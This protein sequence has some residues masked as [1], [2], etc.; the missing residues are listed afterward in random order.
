MTFK[1]VYFVVRYFRGETMEPLA[2]RLRPRDFDMVVGQDHLVGKNGVIRK[3]LEQNRLS[4]L[5]LFGP[6]GSGKTTIAKIVANKF[7]LNVFE[8]NASTDNKEKLKNISDAQYF[9]DNTV[10]IIDE[11]HRMKKDIQD[12]LLPFL[13]SGKLIMIGLTTENPYQAINPAIRSRCMVYRLKDISKDD[14]LTLLKKIKFLDEYK[15]YQI[16][17]EILD[18]IAYASNSEIRTALNMFETLTLFDKDEEITLKMAEDIIGKKSLKL[19]KGGN[20]YYDLLSAL[21]KSIRGSDVDAALHYLARLIAL[22][23]LVIITRRLM[24]CAY[25]DISVANPQIGP[26]VMA[27]CDA[28]LKL[29][30]PE[31]RIPLA[32]IVVDMALSP[33]SN[34]TLSAFDQAYQDYINET[35][36][37]IPSHILNREIGHNGVKYLYPHDFKGGYVKQQYLPDKLKDRIYYKAKETGAYERALKAYND[38]I[39]K[40]KN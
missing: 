8:F 2:Y 4:S 37:D 28:A 21:Q 36:I 39:K 34:S 14:V 32:S 33:K 16:S 3:M 25:E 38:E 10:I 30:L 12:Y 23:D 19:D 7:S 18:F 1:M 11:I 9:Y 29:G 13:E 31:A 15:D 6:P 40:N 26:R 5:I 24:A 22:E 20:N 17:D 35:N 27:A